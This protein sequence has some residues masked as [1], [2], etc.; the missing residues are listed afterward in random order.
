MAKHSTRFDSSNS[1]EK[2]WRKSILF[3]ITL[4]KWS[5][6]IQILRVANY[7]NMRTRVSVKCDGRNE[8]IERLPWRRPA[9]DPPPAA[10]RTRR[11][12]LLRPSH[13]VWL[14]GKARKRRGRRRRR[15]GFSAGVHWVQ[16]IQMSRYSSLRT[17]SSD[18]YFFENPLTKAWQSRVFLATAP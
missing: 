7:G 3:D 15:S 5:N 14:K 8:A 1:K 6:N 4:N 2:D 11:Q 17:Q 16:T 10:P 12:Y 9:V 18:M 13:P